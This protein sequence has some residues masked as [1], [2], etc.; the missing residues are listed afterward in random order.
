MLHNNICSDNIEFTIENNGTADL[1]VPTSLD[2]TGDNAD[3]FSIQSHPTSPV[4][5]SATTTFTVRF[6]P[7]SPGAKTAS[8][9]M[10]NNDS[11]ENP[12]DL[13]LNGTGTTPEMD[14]KQGVTPKADGDN[15]DFGDITSGNYTDIIFTIENTGTANLTLTTPLTMERVCS[16][17][18]VHL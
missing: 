9:S 8:I 5:A 4:S 18:M 3:Q 16:S 11:D 13:T 14:L 2:I 7:T 15:Q 6:T 12:Y 10:V 1:T 17:A